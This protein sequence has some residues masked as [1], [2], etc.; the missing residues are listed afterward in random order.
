[1]V[2][3]DHDQ[4][5][6][7]ELGHEFRQATIHFAQRVSIAFDVAAVAEGLVEIDEVHE[8]ERLVL[9]FIGRLQQRFEQRHVVD[10][11]HDARDALGGENVADLAQADDFAARILDVVE[12]GLAWRRHRI[13][14]AIGRARVVAIAARERAGD[15]AADVVRFDQLEGH[16]AH[17]IQ[18]F[19]A[20]RFFVR[21]DLHHRVARGID[22]QLAG[23]DVLVTMLVDDVRA[24]GMAVAEE[25]GHA[26]QGFELVG[27][28]G[29]E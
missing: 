1:M 9:H 13:V 5:A 23:G 11:L 29:R 26:G 12:Q 27:Q 19:K 28:V 15:E 17:C 14:V 22:N 25:A 6:F 7:L 18:A 10:A 16:F 21:G 4:V 20:E 2:G 8:R 3:G 24:R